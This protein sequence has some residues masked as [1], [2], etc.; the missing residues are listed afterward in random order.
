MDPSAVAVSPDGTRVAYGSVLL[1]LTTM[2]ATT[3]PHAP[4]REIQDGYY[5][6]VLIHGFTDQGLVDAAAPFTRGF[7][8]TWLLRDDGT[9]VEVYPPGSSHV[10]QDDPADLAVELDYA[11]DNTDTCV[12]SYVLRATRRGSR[13]AA[14]A[15]GSTSARPCRRRPATS[16]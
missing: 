16:G 7:G 5:T 4:D 1:D 15:W 11:D 13:T 8:T 9:T 14:A 2:H 6:D 12:T 10:S 3:L